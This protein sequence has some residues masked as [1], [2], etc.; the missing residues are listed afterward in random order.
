MSQSTGSDRSTAIL[1]ED[2]PFIRRVSAV[3]LERSGFSVTTV[4]DGAQALQ[5]LEDTLPDVVILDGMMP[6]M[7]GLEACRRIRADDRTSWVPVILLS[8]RSQYAD[9]EA[10]RDA[11]ATA[12]IRKPF[13]ALTLGARVRESLNGKAPS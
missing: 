10:A 2:D 13:D 8:A 4:T 7:D 9:E 3:A 6:N 1:A 11:G 12:Y 5:L